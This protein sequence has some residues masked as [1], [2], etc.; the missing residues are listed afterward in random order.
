M[1]EADAVVLGEALEGGLDQVG[2]DLQQLGG[3][4]RQLGLGSVDVAIVAHFVQHIE[5]AGFDA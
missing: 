1:V 3:A 2:G 4:R 5:Q